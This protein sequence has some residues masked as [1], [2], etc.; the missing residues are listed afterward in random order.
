[1]K[2]GPCVVQSISRSSEY[3]KTLLSLSLVRYSR[4][5]ATR[6]HAPQHHMLY[7]MR[8]S[9]SS[10]SLESPAYFMDK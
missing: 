10:F 4:L 3:I 7:S 5:D 6:S 2:L 8:M 1:M 9:S